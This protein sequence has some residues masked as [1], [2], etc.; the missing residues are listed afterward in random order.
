MRNVD[1][2]I[3]RP[4]QNMFKLTHKNRLLITFINSIS[5]N[6][7]NKVLRYIKPQKYLGNWFIYITDLSKE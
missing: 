3:L 5:N 2:V 7:L 6:K 1:I 4:Y